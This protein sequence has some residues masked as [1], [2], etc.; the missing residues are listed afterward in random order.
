MIKSNNNP[1]ISVI[2]PIYNVEEYI[3]DCIR[4]SVNQ[5]YKNLEI[6][7][8]NDGSTDTCPAICDK[9]AKSD[10]RIRVIHKKNGGLSDA[11]NAGLDICTGEFIVFIDSDDW[12]SEKY[13]ETLLS[14]QQSSN[15][16]L[17]SCTLFLENGDSTT[18]RPVPTFTDTAEKALLYLYN[19]TQFPVSAWGKLYR[20]RI[21]E[22]LRFPV[23]KICEDAFTTYKIVHNCPLV[24]QINEPLYHYRQRPQSIM[25]SSFKP[26]RMDEEEAWR[27]N[28]EFTKEYYPCVTPLAFSFYLQKVNVLAHFFTQEDRIFYKKEYQYLKGILLSN[29]PQ[30]LKSRFI[31]L[32]E[33]IKFVHDLLF[34][35]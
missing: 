20:K 35:L 15:A 11:R 22:K 4:S 33:K 27:L 9:W 16:D 30:F 7:L 6:I 14:A 21:W 23:G 32:K 28:Y 17:V 25:T 13:V 29:M 19:Q 8:V 18:T 5:T 26:S 3:D 12:V 34:Y 24:C 31:G 2:I 10:C 1:L